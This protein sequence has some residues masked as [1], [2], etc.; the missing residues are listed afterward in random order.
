M[1][2]IDGL[3]LDLLRL[4]HTIHAELDAFERGFPYQPIPVHAE[5]RG[6]FI[7]WV[8]KFAPEAVS[9]EFRKR[10]RTFVQRA[11]DD[12]QHRTFFWYQILSLEVALYLTD[13]RIEELANVDANLDH[14][15]SALRGLALDSFA[16][17]ADRRLFSSDRLRAH[18]ASN[19]EKLHF[20][21]EWSTIA[22]LMAQGEDA[23]KAA[24]LR[25]WLV[26]YRLNDFQREVLEHVAARKVVANPYFADLFLRVTT[27]AA[28]RLG[29]GT[30]EIRGTELV[31]H[32]RQALLL[33]LREEAGPEGYAERVL[34]AGYRGKAPKEAG[35]HRF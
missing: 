29:C 20:D 28:L 18:A 14:H 30:P 27:Y 23:A 24:T 19:L 22:V 4:D 8:A 34:D 33:P 25:E 31:G 12:A 16:F 6:L 2:D 5:L 7:A 9:L 32:E 35:R 10:L 13:G 11:R 21:C 15:S 3:A 26:T 1:S 17:V